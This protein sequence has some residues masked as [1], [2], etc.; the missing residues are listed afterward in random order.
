MFAFRSEFWAAREN[1]IPS[2]DVLDHS[3]DT[4]KLSCSPV[5]GGR[6]QAAGENKFFGN[7]V[8]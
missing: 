4:C 7:L 3:G 2:A 8:V 1:Q 5:T 6:P